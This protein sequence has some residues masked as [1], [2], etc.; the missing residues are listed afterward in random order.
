MNRIECIEIE[1]AILLSLFFYKILIEK[2]EYII[3][4]MTECV[5]SNVYNKAI[6]TK[7]G[8]IEKMSQKNTKDKISWE[9]IKD[10]V[11]VGVVNQKKQQSFLE[12]GRIPCYHWD[13]LSFF[14]RLKEYNNGTM[15]PIR[16]NQE[17]MREWDCTFHQ[18]FSQAVKNTEQDSVVI[19]AEKLLPEYNR[20]NIK[21][22][23]F[24]FTNQEKIFG[25]SGAF[26]SRK[27]KELAEQNN[28]SLFILPSSVHEAVL[29]PDKDSLSAGELVDILKVENRTHM[30]ELEILSDELYYYDRIQKIFCRY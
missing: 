10:S 7:G 3:L 30:T 14:C 1:E 20:K 8:V 13:G 24:V 12:R 18:L 21:T 27:V 4:Q 22:Q 25:A 9:E 2:F 26:F 16:I 11:F 28:S 15:Q 19:Q 6:K 29:I 5:L 23:V 17:M